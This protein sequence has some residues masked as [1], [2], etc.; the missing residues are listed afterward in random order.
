MTLLKRLIGEAKTSSIDKDRSAIELF[1]NSLV[2]DLNTL[3]R[4]FFRNNIAGSIF[5]PRF[6]RWVIL[7]LSGLNIQTPKIREEC[8]FN[9]SY[10]SVGKSSSI[11]RA[12]YFEGSGKIQIGERSNIG[13]GCYFL[14]SQHKWNENGELDHPFSADIKV[15]DRVWIGA[16]STILPGTVIEDNCV[17]GAGSLVKGHLKPNLIYAGVPAKPIAN[18]TVS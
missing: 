9:N 3:F 11:N 2:E 14:T 4:Q 7:R 17:I 6:L 15:G 16:R 13:P 12:C 1:F 5:V 8:R 18:K 10:V